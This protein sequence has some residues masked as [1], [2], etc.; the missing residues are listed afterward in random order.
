MDI[1]IYQKDCIWYAFAVFQCVGDDR[2]VAVA[3]PRRHLNLQRQRIT[4][5]TGS[6]R[7]IWWRWWEMALLIS[8]IEL[9]I[10]SCPKLG[11]IHHRSPKMKAAAMYSRV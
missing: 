4:G 2:V 10:S 7:G 5:R 6:T 3:V 1:G 11:Q 9:K 8:V